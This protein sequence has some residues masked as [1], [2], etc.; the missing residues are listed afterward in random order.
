M[1]QAIIHAFLLEGCV[2]VTFTE[3]VGDTE[4]QSFKCFLDMH[5]ALLEKGLVENRDIYERI[6]SEEESC[7]ESMRKTLSP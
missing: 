7:P 4:S 2:P 1:R 3:R 5:T 6:A